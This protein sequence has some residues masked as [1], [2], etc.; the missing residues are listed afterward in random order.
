MYLSK[1]I[2]NLNIDGA[3]LIANAKN[4]MG[5]ALDFNTVD[6]KLDLGFDYWHQTLHE[7]AFEKNMDESASLMA[8]S[9]NYPLNKKIS[10]GGGMDM[11]SET[12]GGTWNASWGDYHQ[13][14]GAMDLVAK[15]MNGA[16]NDTYFNLGYSLNSW[17]LGLAYHMMSTD[18]NEELGGNEI[19]LSLA[20]TLNDHINYGFGYSMFTPNDNSDGSNWMYLQISATP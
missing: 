18:D 19:D 14:N 13:F 6:S 10:V 15:N 8:I 12:N 7:T 9:I 16:W 1:E 17:H 4:T 11:F 3:Y 5:I 20:N 2:D